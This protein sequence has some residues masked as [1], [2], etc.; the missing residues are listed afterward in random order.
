MIFQFEPPLD[1]A[2]GLVGSDIAAFG[3]SLRR[4]SAQV[5]QIAKRGGPLFGRFFCASQIPLFA[6]PCRHAGA[7][8]QTADEFIFEAVLLEQV[9]IF[10][11]GGVTPTEES[12]IGQTLFDQN[13]E[14][15]DAHAK[16][17]NR[18]PIL[19]FFISRDS[20]DNELRS[21]LWYGRPR[22]SAVMSG[23]RHRQHG[24]S[25]RCH[26]LRDADPRFSWRYAG[27]IEILLRTV[28]CEDELVFIDG[29]AV[30]HDNG[31]PRDRGLGRFEKSA[32]NVPLK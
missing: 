14:R 8:P 1:L 27:E 18:K 17:I 16:S 22:V 6:D 2:P 9:K 11:A 31:D 29:A 26:M 15:F 19:Q 32:V 23:E 30:N 21:S 7:K 20:A 25:K 24:D 13:F 28:G 12:E 5:G 10:S 4:T 3:V